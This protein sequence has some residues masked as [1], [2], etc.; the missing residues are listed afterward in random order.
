M[1]NKA[2]AETQDFNLVLTRYAHFDG[3]TLSQA[4]RATFE[5][6]ATHIPEGVP[7]GLTD[8]W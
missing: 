8:L 6:R 1:L 2:T 3:G 5:R 7:F 4:T